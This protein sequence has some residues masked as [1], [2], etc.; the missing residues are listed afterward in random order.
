MQ[1]RPEF[2]ETGNCERA[3]KARSKVMVYQMSAVAPRKMRKLAAVAQPSLFQST[4]S[5]PSHLAIT[6]SKQIVFGMC[7][8]KRRLQS[9]CQINI[10]YFWA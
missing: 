2:K 5:D 10:P 7:S 3:T 6:R 4:H 8:T 9:Q 1:K